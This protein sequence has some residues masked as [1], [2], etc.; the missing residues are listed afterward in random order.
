MN[1]NQS[2]IVSATGQAMFGVGGA[3]SY[4]T[5]EFKGYVVSLEWDLSEGTTEPVMLMWSQHAGRHAGVFGICL[6]SVGKYANP[7]GT[8]T[9][10]G[11]IECAKVLPLLGKDLRPTELNNLMDTVM[12]FLPDLIRMP[13][14]P[15][16]IRR[17]A[18]GEAYMD[19][20]YQNHDGKTISEVSL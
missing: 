17:A 13:P 14:A 2:A 19:I 7:N 8:P 11:I 12:R 1:L 16:A 3:T 5:H 4:A 20:E 18:K 9:D 6:S 10:Q 15:K